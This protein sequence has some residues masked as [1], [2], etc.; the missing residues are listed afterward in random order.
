[1]KVFEETKEILNFKTMMLARKLTRWS[2]FFMF[3]R[4]CLDKHFG[5]SVVGLDAPC[6]AIRVMTS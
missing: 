2:S 6:I 3:G 1:M 5:F 4:K